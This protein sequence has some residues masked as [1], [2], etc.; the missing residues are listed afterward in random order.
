MADKRVVPLS[1]VMNTL[2][3]IKPLSSLE[4][5]DAPI[6]ESKTFPPPMYGFSKIKDKDVDPHAMSDYVLK[7]DNYITDIHHYSEEDDLAKDGGGDEADGGLQNDASPK[8]KSKHQED[9]DFDLYCN[10]KFIVNEDI[11]DEENGKEE[12]EE[13]KKGHESDSH[14]SPR[15]SADD[16]DGAM[17]TP[18]AHS[19]G[20]RVFNNEIFTSG[21]ASTVNLEAEKRTLQSLANLL[22]LQYEMENVFFQNEYMIK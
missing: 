7:H 10:A 6:I 17:K 3:F 22:R 21:R 20:S 1:K 5:K 9:P 15:E 18:V 14:E 4:P 8:K 12:T 13:T 2:V 19:E 16:P 11:E